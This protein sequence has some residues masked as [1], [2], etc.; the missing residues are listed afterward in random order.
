M[1]IAVPYIL[2]SAGLRHVAALRAT[3]LAFMEPILNPIWVMLGTGEV[4][5]PGTIAGGL[6][7]LSC[8]AAD[9]VVRQNQLRRIS[10]AATM[11]GVDR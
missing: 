4:P 6:V 1:Q 8:L 3:L 10:E 5:G 11:E 2:F 7:I 9:A